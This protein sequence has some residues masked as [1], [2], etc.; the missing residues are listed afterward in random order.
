MSAVRR[1][2][3]WAVAAACVALVLALGWLPLDDAGRLATRIGPVVALLAALT[4]VAELAAHLGVFDA[5]AQR[6]ATWARG[7]RAVLW[8]L[9]VLL[10]VLCTVVLSLDTTAV[11]LTPVVVAVAVRTRSAPLP[12]ALTVL[13]LANTASLALPVSN[14]TNLLAADRFARSDPP[15]SYVPTMWLPAL[16]VLVVAVAALALW[17][18]LALRGR[19]DVVA[20]DAPRDRAA[21]RGASL[22][23]AAMAL[24]F[25]V[26]L[27]P[28]AAAT[29]AAVLLG[30]LALGRGHGLPVAASRLVPW[31]ML[32]VVVALL[33]LVET[34][35]LHGL[36]DTLA[37]LAGSGDDPAAVVRLGLVGA[38]AANA[39]NN[40][41]AYL[42][43]E[44][45]ALGSPDRLAALL[46]G[47]DAG[48]LIT[49]WAS[50][51]TILWWQQYGRH[52]LAVGTIGWW[53]V[54]RQ[55]LVLT[56]LVLAA[57]LAAVVLA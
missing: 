32:V 8:L 27:P 46:V 57:G 44:P 49:P 21:L 38:V 39:V 1:T 7:R 40:L 45:A 6:A 50:L 23:L 17:H 55:G 10:A 20:P 34:W 15:A 47:V 3:V 13:A 25:A 16:A 14:L 22:V 43:L 30:A 37:A 52:A 2:P 54:V 9:V 29:G 41:P 28:W 53:P 56:P 35:H 19:Y 11:L 4:V 33:V 26:E 31:R 48:P 18:R 42:A 12:F 24:C 36:G 5:A 51:A